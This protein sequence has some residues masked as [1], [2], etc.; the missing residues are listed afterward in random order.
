MT[1]FVASDIPENIDSIE[2][3]HV[4]TSAVLNRLYPYKDT[5]VDVE[6]NEADGSIIPV[7]E[8]QAQMGY[9]LT[10][11]PWEDPANK[12]PGANS[13]YSQKWIAITHHTFDVQ[14]NWLERRTDIW[15]HIAPLGDLVIP[16]EMKFYS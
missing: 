10:N 11:A 7:Y 8:T 2:K 15:Q 4:W 16:L 3:L 6:I 5:I 12:P 9:F 1:A 13:D 14:L